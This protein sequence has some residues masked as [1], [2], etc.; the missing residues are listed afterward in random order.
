M[1]QIINYQ[2]RKKELDAI[3]V[4]LKGAQ[5]ARKQ[6]VKSRVP[7][8]ENPLT[9]SPLD[10]SDTFTGRKFKSNPNATK[11][12]IKEIP[13]QKAKNI[14]KKLLKP[15]KGIDF[16]TEKGYLGS[17][18]NINKG[19]WNHKVMIGTPMTGLLRAEWVLSRYGQIIPTNWS[20]MDSYQPLPIAYAPMKYLVPDAQNVIVRNCLDRNVEWLFLIEQD[21]VIPPDCFIRMNEYMRKADIPII[22]GLYFTKSVPPEPMIYR[23]A[24]NSFFYKWKIGERVWCTGLPTGCVI[25]HSSILRAVWEE[26]AEYKVGEVITRRVFEAPEKVWYDPQQG[27]FRTDV[28]TSDLKFCDRVMKEGFFEKAGWSKYQKMKNPFLVDTNIFVKHVDMDGRLF[29]LEM[30]QDYL[31]V[32]E[33]RDNR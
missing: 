8:A 9:R 16:D 2:K 24:G 20:M 13:D 31:P 14:S 10:V 21:N 19:Y 7:D 15:Q 25:I 22:S 18:L 28:G 11:L 6:K 23:G 4:G 12:P 1:R 5:E 33:P 29:P 30:P 27:G 26:S 32:V 17:E 3:E